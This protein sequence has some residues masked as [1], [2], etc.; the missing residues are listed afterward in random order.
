M[1][2]WSTATQPKIKGTWN[3]HSH[4]PRDLDFFIILSSMSGI[5]GNTAQ[6]NYCAGNTYEDAM[7]HYRHKQGL[8]ATTLNVGLV[9]D[10]SHFTED[11]TVDDYLKRYSHWVPAQVTDHEMQVTLAAA[12]RGQTAAGT[13][14]PTQLL[15]GITDDVQRDGLN[16]WP[17]DR[18]FDHRVRPSS[19]SESSNKSKLEGATTVDIAA[20]AAR[21]ALVANV[22]PAIAVAPE[23]IDVE[24]PLYSFGGKHAHCFSTPL[25]LFPSTPRH[26][27]L[28]QAM[29]GTCSL[30]PIRC[31]RLHFSS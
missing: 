11:S 3:L 15:V 18:K 20:A 7:A 19:K 9:T 6:A 8:A 25:F 28:P 14:V 31:F 21:D 13:A 12:M 24:K 5:I 30:S 22:A 17:N 16:L 26:H 23:D 4:M 27:R 29:R 1:D 10:A 2:K